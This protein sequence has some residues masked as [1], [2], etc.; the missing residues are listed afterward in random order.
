MDALTAVPNNAE[1][2]SLTEVL[3][4][5]MYAKLNSPNRPVCQLAPR[6]ALSVTVAGATILIS[7][8]RLGM[9]LDA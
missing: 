6:V 7:V 8:S 2:R 4:A 1:L 9:L 5:Y 3:K